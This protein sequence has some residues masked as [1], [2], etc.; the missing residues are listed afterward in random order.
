[1]K[2]RGCRIASVFLETLTV[3]DNSEALPP[4]LVTRI[5]EEQAA[6]LE[7]WLELNDD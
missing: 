4:K 5:R 7:L 6:L 3:F 2:H 1:M